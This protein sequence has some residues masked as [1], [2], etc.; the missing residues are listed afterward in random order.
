M[1]LLLFSSL[2]VINIVSALL[3]SAVNRGHLSWIWV[4]VVGLA[5]SSNWA[6]MSKYSN[7]IIRDGLL[8][9]VV[10]AGTFCLVFIIL[11]HSTGFTLKHWIGVVATFAVFIYW[12]VI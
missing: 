8:W 12:S 1:M 11:G 9:D 10:M 5:V 2:V 3:S 7:S 6:L 4:V